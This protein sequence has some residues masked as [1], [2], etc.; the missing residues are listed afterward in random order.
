M[1]VYCN[2]RL[3]SPLGLK[4]LM[5]SRVPEDLRDLGAADMCNSRHHG[6][7]NS[8]MRLATAMGQ[9]VGSRP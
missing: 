9:V 6:W 3:G 1:H 4:S 8:C 5:F 2:R 7:Y